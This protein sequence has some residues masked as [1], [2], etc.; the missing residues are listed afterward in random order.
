[1]ESYQLRFGKIILLK[2]NLAEVII[3]E[4]VLMDEGMVQEYHKFLLFHLKAPFSLLVNKINSYAYTFEAQKLI[5]NLKEISS[6]AVV[7]HKIT[8]EMAT[9]VLIDLNKSNHWNIKLFKT[10]SEALNWLDPS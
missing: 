5:A 7:T 1:M 8:T 3:D 6:M 9:K 10:R 2:P 4:G